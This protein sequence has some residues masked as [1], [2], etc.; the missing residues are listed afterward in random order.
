MVVMSRL[1]LAVMLA[2]TAGCRNHAIICEDGHAVTDDP[3]LHADPLTADAFADDWRPVVVFAPRRDDPR[4]EKVFS[5]VEASIDGFRERHMRLIALW[6]NTGMEFRLGRMI[7]P[8]EA[9]LWRERFGVAADEFAMLLV[10]KDTTVKRRA[11]DPVP[12]SELFA[13]ID[14]MP[15]RQ[16]EMREARDASP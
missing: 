6:D 3:T 10:G 12:M 15:M 1:V 9:K 4:L 5:D 13:Q 8:E 11:D 14:G 16:R 7:R 2:A